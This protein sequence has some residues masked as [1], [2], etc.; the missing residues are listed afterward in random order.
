MKNMKT[1]LLVWNKKIQ[2]FKL[3]TAILL[4]PFLKG[5]SQVSLI[6][7]GAAYTQNFDGLANSGT[8]S[9]VP[10]G[11]AFSETGSNANATYASGTGSGTGGDTYSF[12]TT[13]GDR[14]FGSQQSGS[15]VPTLGAS[16]V[17][18]TGSTITSLDLAYVGEQWRFGATGRADQ[19]NFEYSLNATSLTNGTWTSVSALNFVTPNTSTVVG[20]VNGNLVGNK[21]SISSTINSLSIAV[22]GT[23]WIRWT[24]FNATGSD[25]GLAIDDFSLT[26]NGSAPVPPTKLVITSIT[27]SSPIAGSGFNVTVQAQDATNTAQNVLANTAFALTTNGNAGTIG[28]TLVGTINAGSNSVVVSGVTLATAGTNVDI[29]ATRTSGDILSAATSPTFNVIGIATQLAF[30]GIPSSGYIST[31]MAAFTVEARRADNSVDVNYT[32]NITISK[33]SGP[34]TLSGT[35]VVPAIAG[36]A[37]FSLLQFD[38]VGTY[39]LNTSASGLTSATS[40]AIVISTSPVMWDFTSASPTGVPSN[41]TVSAMS[42]GNNNGTTPLIS[43]TSSSSGYTGAS[44]TFNAGAAARTGTINTGASGSAY[45]EFTLTPDPNYIVTLNGLSFGSRSTGTGPAAFSI[46]SSANSFA[47]NIGTGTLLTSGSWALSSPSISSI[48]SNAGSG[49]TFRI[50]GHN[51]TGNPGA[52]TA[53]WRIDDVLLNLTVSACTQPNILVNSGSIISGDSFTI[54]PTGA[55]T[56]TFTGGSSIV[57]PTITSNYTVTGTSADGCVNSVGAIST[58]TVNPSVPLTQLTPI[59][60]NSILTTLDANTRPR[61]VPVLNAVD[62]EWQFTDISTGLVVFTKQRGA[63]W[64]DFYLTGYWPNVQYNKT[65]SVKVRAKVGTAWGNYGTACTLTTPS[66]SLIPTQLTSTYCNT[67]LSSFNNSTIIRCVPVTGS[68][69]YEYQFTDVITNSIFTKKRSAQWTDL[70]IKTVY[71]SLVAGKTY[72]VA[73]RAY[74]NGNWGTFG[75]SCTITIPSVVSRFALSDYEEMGSDININIYPN[76][77]SETLNID[78]NNIPSNASIEI[79]NMV[80]ELVLTQQFT[81]LNNSIN[82]SQLTSGLYI[83]KII[84]NNKLLS[85]QKIVKQ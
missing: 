80:G 53:N 79:Y 33:A 51:G 44:G 30:V 48:S 58:I 72:S 69:D 25:D 59:W 73:V 55:T 29:T 20:A 83:A 37:T 63:P 31:N 78:F 40:S 18:N 68:T 27:P 71:P 24:D 43:S 21:T 1:N 39:S 60:C 81:E 26:P 2:Y 67:T 3:I 45:F 16:F 35:T 52:N 66:A 47:S 49:I 4:F 76:P 15:C 6:N 19:L 5:T 10:T 62:Y 77:T 64:A 75:T 84:G 14:A 61:C 56:Y 23:V 46:R 9:S 57:S 36:V 54:T 70:Y 42:Q 41:L 34:G 28:G 50:Y 11:W 74:V 38:Q 7:L 32:G 22:G 85:S 8:S 13:A 17:N 65:Y 82:T 12:G